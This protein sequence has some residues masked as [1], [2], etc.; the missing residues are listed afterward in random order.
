MK[1][2]E[3]LL[4]AAWLTAP[5][6]LSAQGMDMSAG[7]SS[8]TKIGG[9]ADVSYRSARAS[10]SAGFDFGGVDLFITSRPM[11]K[12]QFLS[13]ILF[14]R[15]EDGHVAPDIERVSVAYSVN[16]YARIAVGRFHTPLGYWN[17][18]FHHGA[19]MAPTID[20]P[21][22]AAFEDD[23]GVL[24]MH[25]IG[26][27]VSGREIGKLHLGY[28][29]SLGSQ[30]SVGGAVKDNPSS[31]V[32]VAVSA[33]PIPDFKFGGSVFGDTHRKGTE[34]QTGESLTENVNE[35]VT[36]G[37]ANWNRNRVE[38]IGEVHQIRNS[39]AALG[40]VKSWGGYA[41]V[42]VRFG[43]I[44][45]YAIYDATDA[46]ARDAFFETRNVRNSSVG[47]RDELGARAVVKFELRDVKVP[48]GGR[49]TEFATQL[50]VAF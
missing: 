8:E 24:P 17:T 1:H 4:V 7:S 35:V 37:Y 32:T 39:S 41:Y 22:I 31:G 47:I 20:R 5:M 34:T 46:N 9:F 16:Q 21:E 15:G 48:T 44:V 40:A 29:V 49:R 38:V 19:L 6:V 36:S 2:V 26:A 42:G 28:D 3:K 25:T 18:A 50:A 33:E 13:E 30:L 45:P 12:L 27:M 10:G 23:H 11:K 43:S 14:E